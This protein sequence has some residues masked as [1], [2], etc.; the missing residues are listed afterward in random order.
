MFGQS[1]FNY[2]RIVSQGEG[3]DPSRAPQYGD[4]A[5]INWNRGNDWDWMNPPLILSQA[6]I[7]RSGQR[8][9]WLGG[10]NYDALKEGENTA[11]LFSEW[12]MQ[13]YATPEFPLA[14]L[15]GRG[16][17]IPTESGLSFYPYIREGRRILGRPGHGQ[18]DYFM[19]REQDVRTDMVGRDLAEVAIAI[20]HYAIDM[21]GCR[22][23]NWEESGAANSAPINEY[24]VD[25]I[26][27]PLEAIIPQRLQN[28]LI[29][30]KGIA[31]THIVN[32]ATRVHYGE[33][34]I[35][36]AAGG[37][38]GRLVRD[39]VQVDSWQAVEV[40]ALR[41]HLTNQGLRLEW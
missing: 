16:A 5:M 10:L 28:V 30:G 20:A 1:F 12:L 34:M 19:L 15:S 11:L 6:E 23:R 2:R 24:F 4:I 17:P 32:A 40:Q 27:I 14:H 29:G 37:I 25:P 7:D 22:Y 31:V 18:T 41:Q 13:T 21:H 9:N 39:N 8:Q 3:I 33:W 38:A 26:Y 35:G 36:S